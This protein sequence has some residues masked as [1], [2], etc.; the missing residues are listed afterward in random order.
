MLLS[1]T[2]T[3]PLAGAACEKAQSAEAKHS[4]AAMV[5][6]AME[7]FMESSPFDLVANLG[8]IFMSSIQSSRAEIRI[9]ERNIQIQIYP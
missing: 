9:C 8:G 7:R 3:R 2:I 6:S 1:G 5:S 4:A